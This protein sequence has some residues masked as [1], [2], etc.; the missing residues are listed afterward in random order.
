MC[1][2]VC[3]STTLVQYRNAHA[4]TAPNIGLFRSKI[5]AFRLVP[6]DFFCP[7]LLK[8]SA[9]ELVTLYYY[10]NFYLQ[11]FVFSFFS[12]CRE[13]SLKNCVRKVFLMITFCQRFEFEGVEN[14]E[15]ILSRDWTSSDQRERLRNRWGRIRW[16]QY[17]TKNTPVSLLKDS[18][19]KI[20]HTSA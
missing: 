7:N 20:S 5:R 11:Y 2:C 18:R 17:I 13:F 16:I 6:K 19:V 14:V 15:Q 8:T 1:V 4:H 3:V 12:L 10:N 9:Y